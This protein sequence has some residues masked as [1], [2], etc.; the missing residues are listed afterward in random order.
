MRKEH[1]AQVVEWANY[2]RSGADWKAIHTDFINSQFAHHAEFIQ[3]LLKQERGKEKIIE[4]YK[5]GNKKGYP[6]LC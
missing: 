6:S 2:V 1:L 5:I 4:L 3:N